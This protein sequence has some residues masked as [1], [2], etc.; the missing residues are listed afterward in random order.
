MKHVN[1]A[2][3]GEAEKEKRKGP[4]KQL[5]TELNDIVKK[6]YDLDAVGITDSSKT[7]VIEILNNTSRYKQEVW[8]VGLLW[9]N[10]YE[11]FPNGRAYAWHSC[12]Y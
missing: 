3:S 10:D 4:S 12:F 1:V 2:S 9:K 6:Q 7:R 5:E 11:N 8:E